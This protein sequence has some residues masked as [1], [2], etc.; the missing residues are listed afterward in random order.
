MIQDYSLDDR[1]AE[2]GTRLETALDAAT[3][4]YLTPARAAVF[5][6]DDRWYGQLAACSYAAVAGTSDDEAALRAAT[7]M[8]LL[9][10][11]HRLRG[12]LLGGLAETTPVGLESDAALLASDYL[13]TTA[14]SRLAG[15]DEADNK[16]GAAIRRLASVSAAMIETYANSDA[17]SSTPPSVSVSFVD[18]TAG[19]L[20]AGAAAIGATLAGTDDRHTD[21]FATVGRGFSTS[22]RIHRTLDGDDDVSAA[23]S[24]GLD[25]RRL[26]QHA[27]RHRHDARR[28]LR[29]LSAAVSVE[30]LTAFLE[31]RLPDGVADSVRE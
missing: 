2:I 3:G 9:R 28:A 21:R 13:Y 30:P 8:E 24:A 31:A 23:G 19:A 18:G 15:L 22:R 4:A 10:G 29:T 16:A 26:R 7:A 20:G 1:R 17:R 6:S 14:Y 12:R 25:D 5:E 27:R 11:Y